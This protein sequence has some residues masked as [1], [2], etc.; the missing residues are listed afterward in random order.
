MAHVGLGAFIVLGTYRAWQIRRERCHS[1]LSL[2]NIGSWLFPAGFTMDHDF[3]PPVLQLVMTFFPPVLQWVMTFFH[4]FYDKA[5]MFS[6]GFTRP[7]F[8]P[9]V[10]LGQ[11][12]FDRFYDKTKIGWVVEKLINNQENLHTNAYFIYFFFQLTF[13]RW[14][15]TRPET[16]SG[17]SK[18]SKQLAQNAESLLAINVIMIIIIITI[19][20]IK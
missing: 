9:P 1:P 7:R 5:K 11:D 6:T 4:R 18:T 19:I 12:F 17:R 8:F 2:V 20:T 13:G 15:I 16:T 10:L 14:M 3:F